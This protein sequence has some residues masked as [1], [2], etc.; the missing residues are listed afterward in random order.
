MKAI[1]ALFFATKYWQDKS[2]IEKASGII[3]KSFASTE[4]VTV[5]DGEVSVLG[6][7]KDHDTIVIVPCSGSV[8]PD[9]IKEAQALKTK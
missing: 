2:E 5:I 6:K 8:Q 1:I 3:R 7:Y 9:I 4:S